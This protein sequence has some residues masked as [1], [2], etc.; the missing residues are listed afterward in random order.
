MSHKQRKMSEPAMHVTP[1]SPTIAERKSSAA[2]R[3]RKLSQSKILKN[4]LPQKSSNGGGECTDPDGIV[5]E[6]MDL[7]RSNGELRK[8]IIKLETELS[9]D[10]DDDKH[11]QGQ[12]QEQGQQTGKK[13]LKDMLASE[14]IH[15]ISRVIKAKAER[16]RK[17]EE[18]MG[19]GEADE[20]W[21]LKN[22]MDEM[23]LLSRKNDNDTND[24]S[25]P[26]DRRRTSEHRDVPC[27]NY[28]CVRTVKALKKC[29]DDERNENERLRE[30][31]SRLVVEK[32]DLNR[33]VKDYT[34]GLFAKPR[35]QPAEE[36]EAD[37][38]KPPDE[39]HSRP[40]D[41]KIRHPDPMAGTSESIVKL[42]QQNEEMK[43][44]W[45][46][47]TTASSSAFLEA[48]ANGSCRKRRVT[49]PPVKLS[50]QQH[51]KDRPHQGPEQPDHTATGQTLKAAA[52][53][54]LQFAGGMTGSRDTVI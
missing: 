51:A 38:F 39:P 17:K 16:F 34:L 23:K 30:T 14:K 41:P 1:P 52:A 21:D 42:R 25:P 53:V 15:E 46:M 32:Q 40:P 49:L 8:Y 5:Q 10:G 50:D 19:C 43:S 27:T 35:V 3:V 33:R 9:V 13:V 7:K 37:D 4:I 2:A 22:S 24:V 31:M 47:P 45:K 20:E 11:E 12:G 36:E 6:N 28:K 29:L 26:A 48:D 54:A 44:M 18:K